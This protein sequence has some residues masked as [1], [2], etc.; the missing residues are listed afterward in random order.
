MIYLFFWRTF[1]A[2][3][4]RFMRRP[5]LGVHSPGS[6]DSSMVESWTRGPKVVGSIPGRGG[7]QN[8][9]RVNVLC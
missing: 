1:S 8:F 6:R 2:E 4:V 7:G 9:S 3:E 5:H